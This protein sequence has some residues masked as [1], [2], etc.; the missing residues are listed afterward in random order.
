MYLLRR[1]FWQDFAVHVYLFGKDSRLTVVSKSVFLNWPAY[2]KLQQHGSGV[3]VLSSL[4]LALHNNPWLCDCCLRGLVQFVKSI[5]L[6]IILVNLYLMCRGPVSKA[7]QLFH[8]TE[9]SACVKPQISTPSVNVTIHVGQNVTLQCLAQARPLPTITWI[10]P[11]SMWREFLTVHG[12]LLEWFAVADTPEEKWF[13]LYIASDEALKKEVVH[14]GPGINT[15]TVDDLL[16][17]TKY[18]ACL[19][20]GCQSPHQGQCVVFVTGRAQGGLEDRER[21]LHVTVVLYTVLLAVPVGAYVWA[22]QAPGSCREWGLHCCPL[23][24]KA[25]RCP[26]AVPQHRD[27]SCRDHIA[28]C[29]DGPGHRNAEGDEENGGK[30]DSG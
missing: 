1:E 30:G 4:V 3:K 8:E 24:R 7:G 25:L 6:P 21:L 27:G 13:T 10:Y 22:A 16:P 15:Y 29:E 2:Q 19:S 20:L 18:E 17:G 14:M 5:S 28:V 26:H 23:H 12:I 11:L 9:L